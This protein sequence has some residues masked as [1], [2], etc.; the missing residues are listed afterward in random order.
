MNRVNRIGSESTSRLL[1]EFSIPA[2]VAMVV[3]S[4]YSIIDR[5]FIGNG[6][7]TT[8]ISG[9]TVCFPVIAIFMAFGMLIG[10]GG[11]SCYSIKLG[12]GRMNEFR[13]IPGN[14]FILLLLTSV[15]ISLVIGLYLDSV[16]RMFGASGK[17]LDYASRYLRILLFGLPFQMTGYGMNNFIRADGRPWIAMAT[18][19]IGSAVNIALAPLLIFRFGLGIEGAALSTVIAQAV[20]CI[21]V[22]ASIIPGKSTASLSLEGTGLSIKTTKM[23]TANG[24]GP[25]TM[26][27]GACIVASVYNHQL[28]SYG[29]WLSLSIYGIIH[30]I[31]VF[32]LMPVI[33]ISQGAQP[34][35]G[36]NFGAG[37]EWRAKNILFKSVTASTVILVCGF[38]V[39]TFVPGFLI[40][41]FNPAD[42]ELK[43]AG[44]HALHIFLSMIPLA[45]LQICSSGFFIATGNPKRSVLLTLSRQ[46]IFLLPLLLVLPRFFGLDGI[47][48]AA[49]ASDFA[50]F[51]LTASVLFCD[52]KKTVSKPV[53]LSPDGESRA[54][55]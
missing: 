37:R 7:G 3:Q 14:T 8:A 30:S 38:L 18:M 28:M 46:I 25:F 2:I 5:I 39:I 24:L 19:L 29:G 41:I 48:L 45:A 11:A 43:G 15:I 32:L 33:G 13:K 31:S 34:L 36:Y 26:Q 42:S 1:A 53:I 55:L 17:T 21:W 35:I 22:M 23:I 47:W 4:T 16:L 40:G 54:L 20:S 52:M 9:I 6:A 50:A 27:I 51:I 12:E 10:I 44:I 49:P